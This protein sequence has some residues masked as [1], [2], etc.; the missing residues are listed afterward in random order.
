[1][2]ALN[3]REFWEKAVPIS[4][5]VAL[6]V[7]LDIQSDR[8]YEHGNSPDRAEQDNDPHG[9]RGSII[10]FLYRLLI[11]VW[12]WLH[13]N[14][15]AEAI[16][17]VFTILLMIVTAGLWFHTH[18]IAVDAEESNRK[19]AC[20]TREA[21]EISRES[22]DAAIAGERAYV[23]LEGVYNVMLSDLAPRDGIG[24][25]T[26][27]SRKVFSGKFTLR[28]YGK[29]PAILTELMADIQTFN[30]YGE[31]APIRTDISGGTILSSGS[32]T[33]QDFECNISMQ[34]YE[35]AK[36]KGRPMILFIGKVT[37]KDFLKQIRWTKFSWLYDFQT[38]SFGVSLDP[39]WNDWK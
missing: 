18:A 13:G 6:L 32:P 16:L 27:Y 5:C 17:A 36:S 3:Q 9:D 29:T 7:L 2:S 8:G 10:F 39:T 33:I 22:A 1:M 12:H 23:F 24:P 37:Y 4:F 15:N 25:A 19:Q 35:A 34:E 31:P 21:L 20:L 26:E 11:D 38:S 30:S 14:G 28:N